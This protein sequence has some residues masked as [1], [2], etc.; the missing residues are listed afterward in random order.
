MNELCVHPTRRH[1]W[2]YDNKVC[3]ETLRKLADVY[4]P[5]KNAPI[6]GIPDSVRAIFA[7]RLVGETNARA[8]EDM[9]S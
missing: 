5:E 9:P 6:T 8:Q 1:S 4:H 3:A 7:E 2:K